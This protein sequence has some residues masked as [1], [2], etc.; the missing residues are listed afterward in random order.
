MSVLL[1]SL[2]I[3]G[4]C[5]HPLVH[6]ATVSRLEVAMG[7]ARVHV[8]A[9]DGRQVVVT[10]HGVLE[11]DAIHPEGMRFSTLT[12]W[13]SDTPPYRFEFANWFQPGDDWDPWMAECRLDIIASSF[14]VRDPERIL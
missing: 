14:T 9:G 8:E 12:C 6:D 3:R 11:V 2:R 10:F 13:D 5:R 1:P 4:H 7:E